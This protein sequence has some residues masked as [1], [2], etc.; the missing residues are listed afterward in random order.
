MK[1]RKAAI[2]QGLGQ[3]IELAA[4]TTLFVVYY[5]QR[6]MGVSWITLHMAGL[7]LLPT[8]RMLLSPSLARR[9][10]SHGET[11]IHYCGAAIAVS[12]LAALGYV[13]QLPLPADNLPTILLFYL[14]ALAT[15][16]QHFPGQPA[17]GQRRGWVAAWFSLLLVQG[18]AVMIVGNIQVLERNGFALSWS[19]A[20][21]LT[22]AFAAVA[23][24]LAI[25]CPE[26]QS[27]DDAS[28]ATLQMEL[29][30]L[31]QGGEM[32]LLL[33]LLAAV[34]MIF[35][36]DMPHN[37][38]LGM[39]PQEYAFSMGGIGVVA[40][41]AGVGL[42]KRLRRTAESPAAEAL[43][44]LA[45]ATIPPAVFLLLSLEL[46]RNLTVVTLLLAVSQMATGFI[47]GDMKE[48][49]LQVNP[50][51]ALAVLALSGLVQFNLGYRRYFMLCT[52][53]AALIVATCYVVNLIRHAKNADR[54]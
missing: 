46:P 13:V 30:L 48:K 24:L 49:T 51:I 6:R 44:R 19:T 8:L 18:I 23:T 47:L 14:L 10:G 28:A 31:T 50:L 2:V 34:P 39:A 1:T 29:P 3:A 26:S 5:K 17:D 25:A 7:L 22:A 4:L 32:T 21:Y 52:A 45:T 33:A 15:A 20:F 9:I 38:G 16:L 54:Q 42:Q 53:C 43:L 12:A 36:I 35:L 41:A 11:V 27:D 37:G 40:I